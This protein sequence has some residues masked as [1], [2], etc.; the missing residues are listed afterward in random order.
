VSTTRPSAATWITEGRNA[1]WCTPRRRATSIAEA[2]SPATDRATFEATGPR[3][4]I[5]DNDV[6]VTCSLITYPRP[7]G[8]V[9]TSSTRASR[10]SVTK[11][12]RRAASSRAGRSAG[13]SRIKTLRPKIVSVARDVVAP[14]M[15][16]GSTLS[17]R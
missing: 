14:G 9:P 7:S 2:V 13:S 5:E 10:A 8:N 12:A 3:W 17:T 11:A 1:R 15:S 4:S 6:P 16:S